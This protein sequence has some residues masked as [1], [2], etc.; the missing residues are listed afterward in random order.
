MTVTYVSYSMIIFPDTYPL[1]L[2]PAS[3]SLSSTSEVNNTV[4]PRVP[5]P[6]VPRS[7][8]RSNQNEISAVYANSP[9]SDGGINATAREERLLQPPPPP[10]PRKPT[11][12]DLKLSFL[13]EEMVI[14]IVLV[15]C[16]S[17]VG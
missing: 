15:H 10:P 7:S 14:T 13:R 8:S 1:S 4:H 5:P 9:S 3:R 6:A 11:S 17:K 16:L 2:S 12:L